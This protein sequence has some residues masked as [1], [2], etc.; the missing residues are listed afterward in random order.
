M[1]PFVKEGVLVL[2]YRMFHLFN[3]DDEV[4][5]K[6]SLLTLPFFHSQLSGKRESLKMLASDCVGLSPTSSTSELCD[7][8]KSCKPLCASVSPFTRSG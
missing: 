1:S 4:S 3:Y 8:G 6:S 7:L 2:I 5:V